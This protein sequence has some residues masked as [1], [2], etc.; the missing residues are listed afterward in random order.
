MSGLDIARIKN[1]SSRLCQAYDCAINIE[2]LDIVSR[3]VTS[4]YKFLPMPTGKMRNPLGE[5]E[6]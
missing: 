5:N 3:S 4:G 6:S 1:V 2:E